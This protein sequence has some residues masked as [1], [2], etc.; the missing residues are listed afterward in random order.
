[1][2]RTP[3]RFLLS[4]PLA[5]FFFKLEI[6]LLGEDDSSRCGKDLITPLRHSMHLTYNLQG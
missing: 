5:H 4:N 1:M 6:P 3:L 2:K